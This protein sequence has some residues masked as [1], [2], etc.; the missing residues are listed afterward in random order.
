MNAREKGIAR[1]REVKKLLQGMGYLIEGPGYKPLWI[2]TRSVPVH[3]DF[4]GVGD[5]ISYFEG[6]FILHQVTDLK[7]KAKHVKIAQ[8]AH[9]PAWIWSR[10]KEGG[11]VFYRLFMV[12]IEGKI[13][14]G[15]I[16]WRI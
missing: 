11:K 16:Q 15:S 14:E 10:A 1:V 12:D 3:S 4:F 5:L 13:E 2:G 8:E 9:I 7:N 6:K